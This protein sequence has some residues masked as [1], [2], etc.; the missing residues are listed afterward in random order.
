VNWLAALFIWF[1]GTLKEVGNCSVPVILGQFADPL[2]K[3]N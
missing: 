2:S 3:C 1:A